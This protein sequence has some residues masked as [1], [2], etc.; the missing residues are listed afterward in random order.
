MEST[1]VSQMERGRVA[2]FEEV[3][4]MNESLLI[5]K[6]LILVYIIAEVVLSQKQIILFGETVVLGTTNRL[7]EDSS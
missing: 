1:L 7:F 6:V 3:I 2:N 5:Q 4:V